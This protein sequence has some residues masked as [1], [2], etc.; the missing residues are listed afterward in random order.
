MEYLVCFNCG[1]DLFSYNY[2]E[3]GKHY[4]IYRCSECGWY[5]KELVDDEM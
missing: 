2:E 1:E 3:E 4:I 5:R